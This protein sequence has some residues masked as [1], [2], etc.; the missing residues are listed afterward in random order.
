MKLER[1]IRILPYLIIVCFYIL[2]YG[3]FDFNGLYGQDAHIYLQYSEKIL[4][5]LKEGIHPGDYHWPVYYPLLGA[6]LS[7]FFGGNVLF[8][9]QLVTVLSFAGATYF[10]IRLLHL[11]FPNANS[12]ISLF[13]SLC[14]CCSPF[15]LRLSIVVMSDMMSFC[16]MLGAIYYIFRYAKETTT[17]HF[18]LL[19][20]LGCLAV[21]TRYQMG[22]LLFIPLCYLV[23]VIVK[24]RAYVDIVVG[25]LLAILLFL[26][27]FYFKGGGAFSFS[28]NPDLQGWSILNFFG[29]QATNEQVF[30]KYPNI[31]YVCSIFVHPGFFFLGGGLIFCWRQQDFSNKEWLLLGASM[32][33]YLLF[34]AGIK[35]Q[36]DRILSAAFPLLTIVFFP[37]FKRCQDYLN[38]RLM[39]WDGKFKGVQ[40]GGVC[41]LFFVLGLLNVYTVNWY[42]ELQR[43]EK[44][45]CQQLNTYFPTYQHLITFGMEGPIYSYTD[46]QVHQI[47]EAIV[48]KVE[49]PT[50]LLLNDNML[51]ASFKGSV[52]DQRIQAI[53][54]DFEVDELEQ[55]AKG[56]VL[57]EVR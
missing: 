29:N 50:L 35:L 2:N 38:T 44:G 7:L 28:E 17:T 33:V 18:L 23:G 24:K 15:M 49:S 57:Y 41:F 16:C 48:E 12:F 32:G 42:L 11:L 39:N 46:Y 5:F 56:W 14:W 8:T 19:T 21:L 40:I 6:V 52:Y 55:L 22:I 30:Y 37:A 45:V 43:F 25:G 36:N 51:N 20:M 53:Y 13:V 27:H 31:V 10:L 9:L 34:F 1:I 54:A 4:A 3:F 47:S 26:P